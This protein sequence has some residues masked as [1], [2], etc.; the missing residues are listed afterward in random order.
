MNTYSFA[1]VTGEGAVLI[2]I[3]KIIPVTMYR[4]EVPIFA[5]VSKESCLDTCQHSAYRITEISYV[6]SI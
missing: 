4:L 6:A 3:L 5:C 1:G 2:I